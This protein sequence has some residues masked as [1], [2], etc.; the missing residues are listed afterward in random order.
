MLQTLVPMESEPALIPLIRILGAEIQ[1]A[2][3]PRKEEIRSAKL[4]LDDT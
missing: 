2:W 1:M 3:M 4:L